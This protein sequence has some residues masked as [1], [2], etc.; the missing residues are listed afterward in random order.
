MGKSP[1]GSLMEFQQQTGKNRLAGHMPKHSKIGLKIF[2]F[3]SK[4]RRGQYCQF[5]LCF[6]KVRSEIIRTS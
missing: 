5:D 1:H 3:A 6:Y 2:D 4:S